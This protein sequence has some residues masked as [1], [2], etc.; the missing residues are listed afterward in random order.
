MALSADEIKA[1]YPLPSYNYKVE[2]DGETVAFSSVSGL[3]VGYETTTYKESS[4]GGGA[5]GPRVMHMPAQPSATN[6]TLK[7]GVVRDV[8]ISALY[9]W[10]S[11]T[12]INQTEK[13]DIAIRLCDEEGAAVITW[14][15]INAFPTKL[16]APAFESDSNDAAVESME[17]MADAI[18]VEQS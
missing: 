7:K 10:I 6:I 4:T 2:I 1:A 3:S 8:S 13:K 11:Q 12:R 15:V 18:L 5:P 17:L 14:K 9:A 16:E